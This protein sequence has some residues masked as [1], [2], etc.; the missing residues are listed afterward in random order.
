MDPCLNL[1]VC[2]GQRTTQVSTFTSYLL[3]DKSFLLYCCSHLL[4]LPESFHA[5][6]SPL[7]RSLN[8]F[9]NYRCV[10]QWLYLLRPLPRLPS[11]IFNNKVNP[12]TKE[13]EEKSTLELNCHLPHIDILLCKNPHDTILLSKYSIFWIF[14]MSLKI[15]KIIF[16]KLNISL[17]GYWLFLS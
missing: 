1:C 2:G 16:F 10:L 15:K 13:S 7:L 8:K 6:P 17:E 9:W 11:C 12:V 4:S 3:W 14:I 5:C